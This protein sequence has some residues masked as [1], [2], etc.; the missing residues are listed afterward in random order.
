MEP[1]VKNSTT[2]DQRATRNPI[3][4]KGGRNSLTLTQTPG[5]M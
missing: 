1:L 2:S 3:E 5:R 4:V